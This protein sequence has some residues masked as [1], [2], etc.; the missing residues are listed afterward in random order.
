VDLDVA[1]G[2]HALLTG[3]FEEAAAAFGRAT[4]AAPARA[5][6][7]RGLGIAEEKR[8]HRDA[9]VKAYKRYLSLSP[10][11]ADHSVIEGR[12]AALEHK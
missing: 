11:A 5:D 4:K 9:A 7:W 3:G 12:V 1:A 10:G 2:K 8:G 6:A